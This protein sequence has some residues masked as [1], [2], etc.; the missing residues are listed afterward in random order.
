MMVPG[1]P[2]GLRSRRY[3]NVSGGQVSGTEYV[4]LLLTFVL[5][6]SQQWASHIGTPV[7]SYRFDAVLANEVFPALLTWI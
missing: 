3:S 4:G 7:N 6:G 2:A 1:F 5:G